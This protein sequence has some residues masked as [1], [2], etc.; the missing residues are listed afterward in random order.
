MGGQCCIAEGP[1]GHRIQDVDQDIAANSGTAE[2][3]EIGKRMQKPQGPLESP[4]ESPQ[5]FSNTDALEKEVEATP[6]DSPVVK[7]GDKFNVTFKRTD[8]QK[9][10]FG[11]ARIGENVIIN[12]L[13]SEG[14]LIQYNIE[15]PTNRVKLDDIIHSINGSSSQL[16]D[17]KRVAADAIGSMTIQLERPKIWHVTLDIPK[18]AS[19]GI[20]FGDVL[21]TCIPIKGV[22]GE[23]AAA[24]FNVANPEAAI[25][26]SDFIIATDAV[27]MDGEKMLE[28][29][30]EKTTAGECKIK[31]TLWRNLP[32]TLDRRGSI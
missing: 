12:E 24:E 5:A 18:G 1:A 14:A 7:P 31:C 16:E 30:N 17:L 3:V 22:N 25:A 11:L 6:N 26:P 8:G 21:K 32:D 4:P 9:L 10:G 13:K 19:A 15:N 23:G 27:S 28:H 2:T 29:I 20:E